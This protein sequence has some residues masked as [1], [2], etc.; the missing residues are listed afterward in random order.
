MSRNLLVLCLAVLVCACS[1]APERI[2][3]NDLNTAV[4]EYAYALRWQRIDD[5]VAYHRNRDGTKPDIDTSAMNDV[6][7]T[8]FKIE[9]RVINKDSTEA[10]VTGEF[11]YY[12]EDYGALKKLKF[13]Q[14]WWYDD[15]AGHWYVE[16]P[17]PK[18]K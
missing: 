17:F 9:K 11:D 7:V 5:A 16:S 8:G 2:K 10:V 14:H 13:E 15:D 18:F 3:I 6:R 12:R 4:K 1:S